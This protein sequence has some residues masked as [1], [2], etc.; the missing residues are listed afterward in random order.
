M[1]I[2]NKIIILL[3]CI[4]FTLSGCSVSQ[5]PKEEACI[6]MIASEIPPVSGTDLCMENQEKVQTSSR[7]KAYPIGR[8]VDSNN[9]NIMHEGHVVYR[10][11]AP[12]SWNRNPNAPTAVPLGPTVAISHPER[13]EMPLSVEYE[14][15]ILQQNQLMKSLIDQNEAL[16]EL[17][18]E[19]KTEI[20]ELKRG[21]RA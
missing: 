19:M 18:N 15:K 3:S 2:D 7:L 11:E 21:E 13:R 16:M 14:T 12:A 6:T 17:V 8:Y 9:P 5:A 20:K 10:Q 1:K 4:A